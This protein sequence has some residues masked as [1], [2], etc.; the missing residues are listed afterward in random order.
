MISETS[1]TA[2]P[3]ANL[4]AFPLRTS[5]LKKPTFPPLNPKP[6]ITPDHHNSTLAKTTLE[7][8]RD[9]QPIV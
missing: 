4:C 3:S 2:N 7:T 5:A 1:L 8:K 6:E 9:R